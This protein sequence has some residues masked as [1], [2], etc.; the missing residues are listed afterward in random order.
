M[1]GPNNI[2][3]LSKFLSFLSLPVSAG[4]YQTAPTRANFAEIFST[5]KFMKVAIELL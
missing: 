2:N 5:A 3:V 1:A 4:Q